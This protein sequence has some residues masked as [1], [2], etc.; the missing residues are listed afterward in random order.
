MQNNR[1]GRVAEDAAELAE[2]ASQNPLI[3]ANNTSISS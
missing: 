1:P 3:S 2:G